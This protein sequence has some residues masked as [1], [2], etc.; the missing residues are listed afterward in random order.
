MSKGRDCQ[1]LAGDSER[2]PLSSDRGMNGS[3]GRGPFTFTSTST[4]TNAKA[5]PPDEGWTAT[6]D[7]SAVITDNSDGYLNMDI[8]G[9]TPTVLVVDDDEWQVKSLVQFLEREGMRAKSATS[10]ADA[11]KILDTDTFDLI[12]LDVIMPGMDGYEV[13][14]RI[15]S[16]EKAK[17]IP[18]VFLTAKA[19]AADYMKGMKSGGDTYITKPFRNSQLLMMMKTL[20]AMRRR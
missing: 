15:R 1:T 6:L 14:K 13:C 19:G 7:T 18:V 12:L 20:M 2:A 3:A 9:R 11:L 16:H 5:M 4:S 8:A 17:T 10:G